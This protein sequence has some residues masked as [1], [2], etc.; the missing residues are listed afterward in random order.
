MLGSCGLFSGNSYRFR[1]TVEVETPQGIRVGSSVY[2]VT[3]HKS[4]ALTSEERQGGGGLRGEAVTIDLPGGPLFV[5]LKMR[6]AGE[7]LG[8]AATF[9]LAPETK[10]GNVDAYVAAVRGLAGMSGRAKAELSREGWPIMVRFG[11]IA[12]PASVVEVD[13]QA[14]GVRRIIVETTSDDVTTGIAKRLG[15][16]ATHIGSLVR[17]SRGRSINE[18]AAAEI[19]TVR[20]FSTELNNE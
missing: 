20:D 19:L 5:T 8:E 3:A 14:P 11:D 12:D 18:M 7:D 13:P 4:L 1:M 16:L 2:E 17:R 6:V 9:A 10:R 15:W